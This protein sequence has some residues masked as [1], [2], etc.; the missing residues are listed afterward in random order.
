MKKAGEN[1]SISAPLFIPEPFSSC[2]RS[3]FY[4][5]FFCVKKLKKKIF[6]VLFELSE[7]NNILVIGWLKSE[8][9]VQYGIAILIDTPKAKENIVEKY[10]LIYLFFSNCLRLNASQ[11]HL[12]IYPSY[13]SAT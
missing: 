13:L 4:F 3:L 5:T 8:K 2:W 12:M 10:L 6:S 11:Q 1:I 9:K 7:E